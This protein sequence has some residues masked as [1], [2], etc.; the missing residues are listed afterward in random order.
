MW[1]LLGAHNRMNALAAIAA[2][3]HAGVPAAGAVDA[4]SQFKNVRRRMEIRG[5]VRGVTVYDDFAH[6]PTAIAT[7]I[8][9]LR[10]KVG[11]ARILAVIEPRSN[12]MKLGVMKQALPGSLQ[13]ADRVFCY[14]G[15]LG[16]NAA[17]AL[18]PLGSKASVHE[19]LDAMTAA[20]ASAAC[21]GDHVLV[22]S[23]GGFGGIHG[24]LLQKLTD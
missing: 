19:D 3:R 15:G 13:D 10:R 4:L 6:H 20:I 12:T 18:A 1:D 9:G 16:W 24:R 21:D 17:E 11:A 22:M 2:A 14:S 8:A 5:T 23:N 7:T